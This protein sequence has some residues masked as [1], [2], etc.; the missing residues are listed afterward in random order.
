MM[1]LQLGA[2]I[3]PG[4]DFAIIIR[5]S[6]IKG[7]RDGFLCA[8]GIA[9]A[10]L[11][12]I[13][14]TYLIGN[15]LYNKYH[16]L[17]ILFIGCGLLYLFYISISLIKS[18]FAFHNQK[19][20]DEP[21]TLKLN[22]PFISGLLTNLSNVKAIVFFSALLPLATQLNTPFKLCAWFGM[23]LT[24]L[25]WFSFVSIMFGNNKVRLAFMA[26]IHILELIIGIIIFFFASTIFY[27]S[28][29]KYF[30]AL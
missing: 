13:L 16:L 9:T 18:F 26:R 25:L 15:T 3:L 2:L 19:L 5:Y 21:P 14:I 30:I 24:T 29:Y 20:D 8:S 23:G 11:I 27:E 6:I 12:N 1:A 7:K 17:Y 28:I 4:P 22:A 10:I